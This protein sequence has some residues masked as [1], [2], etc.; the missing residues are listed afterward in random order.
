MFTSARFALF[1]ITTMALSLPLQAKSFANT[2]SKGLG[3]QGYDPV[4]YFRPTAT[5]DG[6]LKGNPSLKFESEQVTYYFANQENLEKFKNNPKAFTPAFGGW[7]A[8]AVAAKKE[9]VEV[10]AKSFLIQDGQLLLFYD[11]FLADTRAKWTEKGPATAE[12]FLKT[13]HQNWPSVKAQE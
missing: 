12:E 6:P 4:S 7:C 2:D 10:D 8:Y 5:K 13:A 1:L 11:G 9:K 3:L